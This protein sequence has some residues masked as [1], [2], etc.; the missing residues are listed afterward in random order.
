[1]SRMYC[2]C[3]NCISFRILMTCCVS[4]CMKT[5]WGRWAKQSLDC[6]RQCA[7]R[8]KCRATQWLPPKRR[9]TSYSKMIGRRSIIFIKP[10]SLNMHSRNGSHQLEIIHILL[11]PVNGAAP[12]LQWRRRRRA[13]QSRQR[14]TSPAVRHAGRT[15]AFLKQG[16]AMMTIQEI[17]RYA[18]H[19]FH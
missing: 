11:G 17:R 4:R 18:E 19:P 14:K 6:R 13:E 15:A 5:S 7:R 2:H 8:A 10:H 9:C 1:M 16:S 12:S 3:Y